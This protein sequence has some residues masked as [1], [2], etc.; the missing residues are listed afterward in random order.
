MRP[1]LP[2]AGLLL[3]AYALSS[4]AQAR[5]NAET[6]LSVL[7]ILGDQHNAR[8]LGSD[9]NG[10]GGLTQSLTPNLDRL[11]E[12]G[13]RF[14]NAFCSQPQCNPSRTSIV[15]GKYPHSHGVRWNGVWEPKGLVTLPRL[16]RD[17]GYATATIGKHHFMWL[18]Q[19]P[20]REEDI[21]F[22]LVVDLPEYRTYCNFNGQQSYTQM[23]AFVSL[24]NLPG[25]LSI[26]GYTTNRNQFSPMGFWADET[27]A[28]L[29]ARAPA[30]GGDGRPF[31]CF[32]SNYGP[33][34]PI[35][36]SAAPGE[37]DWAHLYYPFA[38]LSLPPNVAHIGQ[39][40]RLGNLQ[41]GFAVINDLAWREVLALYYGF[42]TQMDFN[43]GRVLSRLDALGLS[44][45]TLVIYSADHGEMSSE[46]DS[47]TKGGGNYEA[48]A[49][50]PMIVRLPEAIPQDAVRE[51]L[52]SNVDLLPTI[53][54]LTG[55]PVSEED[56][57]QFDGVSFVD[58][59]LE[60]RDPDRWRRT[61]QI[62][63]GHPDVPVARLSRT[64]RGATDK[65][66]RD[67]LNGLEEEYFDLTTDPFEMQ[68]L[69]GSPDLAVQNRISKL[70][71]LLSNWWNNEEG[72]APIYQPTGGSRSRPVE[73]SEPFPGDG[74]S[75]VRRD[76]RPAFLPATSASRQEVFFGTQPNALV[77]IHDLVNLEDSFHPGVLDPLTTYYWRVDGFN[78]NGRR[79]GQVWSFTTDGD[80]TYRP[81]LAQAPSP[82]HRAED[83][84]LL[85]RLEW[86]PSPD[87]DMQEIWYGEEGDL[88]LWRGLAG[89][90]DRAPIPRLAAG[91]N[92]VWRVDSIASPA[93]GGARTVGPLWRFRAAL[94]GLAD[95]AGSPSPAHLA[96]NV[97][98]LQQGASL[99]WQPGF[100]ATLHQVYFG[101]TFPL[102]LVQEGTQT[103]FS[104]PPLVSGR[105]YYWRVDS[106]NAFGSRRGWTWRF[107]TL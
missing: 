2:V 75:S 6:P 69:S 58:A 106:K 65:Y 47:W 27:I 63:F 21:G 86:Q 101:S 71:Q 103:S 77:K 107:S 20:P 45:S 91:K 31:V 43:I 42:I 15:T 57:A 72:H 99:S 60:G 10:F 18:E 82:I 104:L 25:Q 81:G 40:T 84:P 4:T 17:A 79:V 98:V 67:E 12:E 96:L 39:T 78:P 46:M 70:R 56:R 97:P 26:T 3:A 64:I 5:Q 30:S 54:E 74:A 28:F 61:V 68:D 13:T 88:Q 19:S 51:E 8:A 94:E 55:I 22:D 83:V 49:R 38:G 23:G 50:I 7:V 93:L 9:D 53:L 1:L 16:A 89:T 41:S 87:A 85:T 33:H 105:T 66:T 90:A 62:E 32:Y 14:P 102:P 44:D 76:V 34:T 11:A 52:I 24:P 80:T 95:R 29:E 36:P 100:G 59:L 35:L 48:V 73:P 37:T 92:Y